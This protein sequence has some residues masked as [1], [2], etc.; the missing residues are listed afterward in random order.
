MESLTDYGYS[1]M[2]NGSKVYHFLQGVKNTELEAA[3]NVV[4]AQPEKYGT[5]LDT[6]MSYMG[7]MVTKN[8][9]LMQSVHIAETGCQLVK[10]KVVTFM[11]KMDCKKYPKAVWN[12]M[13]K[14]QQMQVR[15]L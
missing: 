11:G 10:L 1:R 5:D 3:V 9:I 13:P 8:S 4:W 14:E 15:K 7:Q 2:D 6:T 12:F